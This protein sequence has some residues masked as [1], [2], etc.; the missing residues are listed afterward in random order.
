MASATTASPSQVA[1]HSSGVA[2]RAARKAATRA[3]TPTATCP[4]PGT[5]VNEPARSIVWR[6]KRRL[7]SA[8]SW[9]GLGA[10][11]TDMMRDGGFDVKYF[12]IQSKCRR[13][14]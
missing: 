4:Q 13:Y 1:S 11:M 5:A 14:V 9:S 2:W 10:T 3:V 7:S 8:R 12:V 6:M